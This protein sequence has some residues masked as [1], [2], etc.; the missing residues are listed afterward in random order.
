MDCFRMYLFCIFKCILFSL[1]FGE[2]NTNDYLKR[3]HSL[4]K[5]YQGSGMAIP[6]WDFLGT[7]MVTSNYIR[8]TPDSQS[9]QGALWNSV[10][11]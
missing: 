7:T 11:S 2:W 8:L 3:E 4:Y 5:P 1:V 9:M 6:Y 10:V